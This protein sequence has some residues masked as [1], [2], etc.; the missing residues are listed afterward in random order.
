MG[1]QSKNESMELEV[2]K[3]KEKEE[4]EQKEK[5]DSDPKSVDDEDGNVDTVKIGDVVLGEAC[6]FLDRLRTRNKNAFDWGLWGGSSIPADNM[7][8]ECGLIKGVLASQ[9]GYMVSPF[10]VEMIGNANI[11]ALDMECAPIAQ[12]LNQ[13]EIDFFALKVISNGIYPGNPELM[14]SEYHDN[15]EMVSKKA[16]EVLSKV[17]D[18]LDGKTK[19]SLSPISITTQ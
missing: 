4:E 12:I 15:R 13:T 14:E 6:L 18:Y 10:Q 16:T 2:E 3:E 9:I 8:K 7:I 1:S 19:A 5:N 17:I 11:I